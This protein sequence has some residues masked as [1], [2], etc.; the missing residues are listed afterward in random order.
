MT[1]EAG[2]KW[3]GPERKDAFHHQI[4]RGGEITTTTGAIMGGH[5]H[6]LAP[7]L[8]SLGC[9]TYGYAI[10]LGSVEFSKRGLAPI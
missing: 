3:N 10:I 9:V 5:R 8:G 7:R 1:N 6:Y 4:D 2:T